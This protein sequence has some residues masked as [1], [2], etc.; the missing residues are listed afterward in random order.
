MSSID[1]VESRKIGADLA[2]LGVDMLDAPVSGGEYC[3]A[4]AINNKE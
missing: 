3:I 2:K 1:P 4:E